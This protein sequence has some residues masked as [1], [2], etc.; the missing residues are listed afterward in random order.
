MPHPDPAGQFSKNT[1][2]IQQ[3]AWCP[4]ASRVGTVI[5]SMEGFQ[6]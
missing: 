2:E 4:I 3:R 1:G 6:M 5:L